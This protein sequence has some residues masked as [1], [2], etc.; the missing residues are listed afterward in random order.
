[1]Q[2]ILPIAAMWLIIARVPAASIDLHVS[3]GLISRF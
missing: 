1:M 3:G 2:Y